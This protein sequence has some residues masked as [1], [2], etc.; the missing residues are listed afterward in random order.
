[1]VGEREACGIGGV[2]EEQEEPVG[3]LDLVATV[4][5]EQVTRA[6]V[7]LGP[8]L[9]GKIVA[10]ALDQQRAV[11]HVGEEQGAPGHDGFSRHAAGASSAA[12][13]IGLRYR[14]A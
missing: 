6:A 2:V 14:P 8:D 4:Q 7:V 11:D 9:R 13:G 10:R 5:R 12:A 1:V 3:A